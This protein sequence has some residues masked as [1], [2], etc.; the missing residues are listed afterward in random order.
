MKYLRHPAEIL[1][2][3]LRIRTERTQTRR[4]DSASAPRRH[5][6]L[7]SPAPQAPLAG[8]ASARSEHGD[9]QR[10][11][12]KTARHTYP[13]HSREGRPTCR[14][15]LRRVRAQPG[16]ARTSA[17]GIPERSEDA[18]EHQPPRAKARVRVPHQA[19]RLRQRTTA[20]GV[21]AKAAMSTLMSTPRE[22]PA[23]TITSSASPAASRS[24]SAP[25]SP[26]A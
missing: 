19:K 18:V 10:A 14:A 11:A 15:R 23:P 5:R 6:E 25:D 8:T 24:D 4:A 13:H 26:R 16:G 7:P 2:H 9:S 22:H 12:S 21:Q 3:R 17:S 20:A 1:A